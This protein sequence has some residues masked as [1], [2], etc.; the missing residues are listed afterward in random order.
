MD[1]EDAPLFRLF[2]ENSS[3]NRPR[4]RLFAARIAEDALHPRAVPQLFHAGADLPLPRPDDALARTM[5]AR[6]SE[7]VFGARPLTAREL[8]SVLFALSGTAE[9]RRVNASAG[10]LYPVEAFAYLFRAEGALDRRLVYYDADTHALTE[11]GAVPSWESAREPLG[12]RDE[13]EPAAVI[14]LAAIAARTTT[15]YGERGGRFVLL[16]IGQALQSLALRVA[17][18][19]LRGYAVGGVY[20]DDVKRQLGLERT[21]VQVVVAYACGAAAE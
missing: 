13:A 14:V 20:D 10:G 15:R 7:R 17:Q 21:S 2:L 9:G 12:M 19:G 6:R 1:D 11:L 5:L 3:L 16:E 8:G 4:A 18:E